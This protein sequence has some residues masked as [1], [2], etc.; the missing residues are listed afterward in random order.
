MGCAMA[1]KVN[2]TKAG[3]RKRIAAKPR[4]KSAAI[5]A[6]PAGRGDGEATRPSSRV[7]PQPSP[8][9][10]RTAGGPGPDFTV[11]GVGAS[12][13]GLEAFTQLLRALP[14]D[15]EV[16]IVYVQHLAP[17]YESSLAALLG[18]ATPMPV[19]QVSD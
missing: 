3:Q 8:Q 11:V 12:A 1:K 4:S 5:K 18:A 17:R 19:A 15:A 16:A 7:E 14:G 13:G 9:P 10:Q 6:P 2:A